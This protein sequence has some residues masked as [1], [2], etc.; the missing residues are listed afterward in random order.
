MK[1]HFEETL[2]A[3]NDVAVEKPESLKDSD[4]PKIM[5]EKL[6]EKSVA[7]NAKDGIKEWSAEYVNLEEMVP[8]A[9]RVRV[10]ELQEKKQTIMRWLHRQ[11][12]A[13]DRKEEVRS[14]HKESKNNKDYCVDEKMNVAWKDEAFPI[15]KG[16]LATDGEWELLYKLDKSLPRD[17]KKE[18]VVAEAK[19]AMR[20]LLNKQIATTEINRKIPI[21]AD[22]EMKQY[23]KG[24]KI[25]YGGVLGT[26]AHNGQ[27]ESQDGRIAE[28]MIIATMEKFKIDNNAPYEFF[29]GDA[30]DDAER[31]LDCYLVIPEH[32]RGVKTQTEDREDIGIQLLVGPRTPTERQIQKK[33]RAI[34]KS[35]RDFGLED[36]DDLVL[37]SLS[38]VHSKDKYDEWVEK[39][40]RP[41]GP[42]KLWDDETQE[43]VFYG[44]LKGFF[45][46]RVIDEMW[47]ESG[48]IKQNVEAFN[49][50]VFPED[51]KP[52]RK[53]KESLHSML[54]NPNPSNKLK[55]NI[56]EKK[57]K[58]KMLINRNENDNPAQKSSKEKNKELLRKSSKNNPVKSYTPEEIA[59]HEKELSTKTD[60]SAAVRQEVNRAKN[61]LKQSIDTMLNIPNPSEKTKWR[62]EAKKKELSYLMI[63]DAKAN[64][65]KQ[66]IKDLSEISNPSEK[67][68]QRIASKKKDL[69]ELK[70]LIKESLLKNRR[71]EM[72]ND[73]KPADDGAQQQKKQPM[74]DK[75]GLRILGE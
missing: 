26:N 9:A 56:E 35:K 12:Q 19:R 18:F 67:T 30:S 23:M 27:W 52:V 28:K 47:E 70:L 1:Q 11:I 72:K 43:K 63:S 66:S 13:I 51:T 58:L 55:K 65:L 7:I 60:E 22:E 21:W 32:T 34:A 53:I 68:K 40:R 36:I 29:H 75:N 25:F 41:G 71:D 39:G 59:E 24:L 8:A 14:I 64:R 48:K 57:R 61:R 44:I 54:V 5:S 49:T 45:K 62:I 15:T 20:D 37:I 38:H 42:E 3:I 4:I 31:K 6:K 46:E 2:Q 69:A 16:E 33:E 73:T 50:T 17:V 74:Y 10:L